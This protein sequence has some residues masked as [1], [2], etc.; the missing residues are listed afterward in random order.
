MKHFYL[1]LL[2]ISSIV[3]TSYAVERNKSASTS[4]NSIYVQDTQPLSVSI[5]VLATSNPLHPT[6]EAT[7]QTDPSGVRQVLYKSFEVDGYP[8][9][10][11]GEDYEYRASVSPM[12]NLYTAYKR[13]QPNTKYEAKIGYVISDDTTKLY[14][15][16]YLYDVPNVETPDPIL[17]WP[18]ADS[19]VDVC[20]RFMT[21]QANAND[22]DA[23]KLTYTIFLNDP[24]TIVAKYEFNL[25]TGNQDVSEISG[26]PIRPKN[27]YLIELKSE[28]AYG[29]IL[30]QKYF[31]FF[32]SDR[33][34]ESLIPQFITPLDGAVNVSTNPTIAIKPFPSTACGQ[35]LFNTSFLIDSYPADWAGDDYQAYSFA[36]GTYSWN[37]PNTLQPNTK[38]VVKAIFLAPGAASSTEL[39]MKEITF[40]TGNVSPEPLHVS[41]AVKGLDGSTPFH[42]VIE[43]TPET[44]STGDRK[45]IFLSREL[46]LYPADWTGTGYDYYKAVSPNQNLFTTYTPLKGS[47]AYVT[48]VAYTNS[49]DTS[50]IYYATADFY[51]TAPRPP[52][53]V[54]PVP[55]STFN[56][57]TDVNQF[58]VNAN[59]N[60]DITKIE[61]TIFRNDPREQ[62]S[63]TGEFS[64]PVNQTQDASVSDYATYLRRSGEGQ[65]LIE[66]KG[67]DNNGNL[68]DQSYSTI[69]VT[70]LGNILPGVTSISNGATDV[71]LN[72]TI[73]VK[74]YTSCGNL[75]KVQ[76]I[77]DTYPINSTGN[78]T[79]NYQSASFDSAVYSWTVPQALKPNT[80]YEVWTVFVT[81]Y[82]WDA[83]R[84]IQSTRFTT[85]TS[86][87]SAR[88]A[89]ATTS[90]ELGQHSLL[91]PNPFSDQLS[92]QLHTGYQKATVSVVS[93]DGRVVFSKSASANEQVSFKD[94]SLPA[95]L[96]LVRI[97]DQ[98]GIKEQFKVVKQ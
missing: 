37:V 79:E 41:L 65:F 67:L 46:D 28:D 53:L 59:N 8:A 73:T 35:G 57:C 1:L 34:S 74:P 96:Y 75:L 88:V 39:F 27:Q 98:T 92:I 29:R 83:P 5:S 84:L 30:K 70:G 64:I 12:Q 93:M 89:G 26:W 47:T 69:F 48:R 17:I 94:N 13:L 71:S 76:Y 15:A 95:G 22:I 63:A 16:S 21:V 62:I 81:D 87:S 25:S 20:G 45:V 24:R 7:A 18:A 90:N 19:Y 9:D 50:K 31:T 66:L 80:E 3:S 72:P 85:T 49:D 23:K 10:W 51:T 33:N 4:V 52:V 42:P 38:Y 6:F 44:D 36:P 78:Y 86:G 97:S 32:T 61:L 56:S 14:Y 68:I 54:Y 11:Q 43:A 40:T 60:S 58:I 2:F 91:S 55:G 77:L 82:P